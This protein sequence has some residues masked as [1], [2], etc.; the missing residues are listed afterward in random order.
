MKILYVE[1]NQ[2]NRLVMERSIQKYAEIVTEENGFKAMDLI[3]ENDFDIIL[4]DLNLADPEIDGFGVLD[5]IKE[6]DV[7]AITAAVTAFT[8]DEWKDKCMEE[9]FHL[10]FPKPVDIDNMW[11][12]ILKFKRTRA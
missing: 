7:P 2:I 10:Y 6:N 3:K 12:E 1:D 8:T 5:Y 9:G 4:I 11:S